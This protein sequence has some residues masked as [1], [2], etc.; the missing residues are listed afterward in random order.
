MILSK[1]LLAPVDD[2]D[3]SSVIARLKPLL[4]PNPFPAN[5]TSVRVL[6]LPFYS[7]AALYVLSHHYTKPPL[8]KYALLGKKGAS[9]LDFT[10]GSLYEF[11]KE[12]GIELT[13][14]TVLDYARFYFR[15]V[16]G[17]FG[18]FYPLE[19]GHKEWLAPLNDQQRDAFTK[20]LTPLKIVR[21]TADS[22]YL[23]GMF[24]FYTLVFEGDV[25]IT[26]DGRLDISEHRVCLEDL[27]PVADVFTF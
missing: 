21:E 17:K 1:D 27:P 15:F 24:A 23:S 13:A 20:L 22:F 6:P 2:V 14:Q 7:D 12:E 18:F 10:N 25:A 16:R 19:E 26:K 4:E 11:N 8:D 9:I 3:F 5:G